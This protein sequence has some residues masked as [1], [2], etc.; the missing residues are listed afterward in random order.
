M[1]SRK[2]SGI[3]TAMAESTAVMTT[4]STIGPRYR[5]RYGQTRRAVPGRT[6]CLVT[7]SSW[8]RHQTPGPS[9]MGPLSPG[10]IFGGKRVS[11]CRPGAGLS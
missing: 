9:I 4:S 3:V 10:L 11:L 6:C 2:I 7:S 1:I 8:N 5:R